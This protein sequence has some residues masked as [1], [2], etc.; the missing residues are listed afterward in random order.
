MK[1]RITIVVN[2]D[3]DVI[4][5]RLMDDSGVTMTYVQVFDFLIHYYMKHANQPATRWS[6]LK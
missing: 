3:I 6:P 2:G 5:Q 1:K 4:K